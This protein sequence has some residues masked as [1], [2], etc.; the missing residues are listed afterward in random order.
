[1]S[2]LFKSS[3]PVF[4]WMP[5]TFPGLSGLG[6]F[7]LLTLQSLYSFS[8]PLVLSCSLLIAQIYPGWALGWVGRCAANDHS[9]F[10]LLK[11]FFLFFGLAVWLAGS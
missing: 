4:C 6:P 3:S 1:M 8:C 9:H 2:L 7:Q 5:R 10:I 11:K